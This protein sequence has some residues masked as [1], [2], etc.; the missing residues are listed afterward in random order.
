MKKSKRPTQENATTKPARRPPARKYAWWPWAVA[1][2]AL[3]L[4]FEAYTP[5]LNGAF[6][7][8]DRALAFD[9]PK[10]SA[11]DFAEWVRGVRPFLMT[12]YWLNY[13]SGGTDPYG[14]HATNV[15]LHFL[16]SA[17]I[18]L[19]AMRLV[20]MAG[21]AGRARTLCGVFAGGLFLL[22]PVQTESVA[23]VASRSEVLSVLLYFSAFALFLYRGSE[24]IGV[25]RALAIVAL[26]GAAVSTKEHTLTL[27]V[28]LVLADAWWGLGG[29]RRNGIVYGLMAV[30]AAGGAVLVWRV[31]AAANTAGFNVQGLTPA[32]Y[33]FTQCRVL[34][35]YV[36]LFF[37]P[38]GQNVDPDVAVSSG[39]L[40]H[41]AILGLAA[42]IA[43]VTVAWIY[44]KRFPLA[45]FGVLMFLLLLAPTSSIVPIRDVLAERR[46]YLPF[47]GLALVCVEVLRRLDFKPMLATSLA[48]LAISTVLTYQRSAVWESPQALWEDA[49]AKSPQ[50][51]RPR[52]QLAYAYYE[53]GQCPQAAE[54]Y[55]RA[56][57]LGAV[58]APLL[59]D[60][61]LALDCA[62]RGE[63]ALARLRTAAAMEPS[64]H[65]YAQIGMVYG[66]Q[67]KMALALEALQQAEQMDPRFEMTYVYRGNV[68]EVSGDRVAAARE[69]QRAVDINPS[70]QTARDALVR[71]SR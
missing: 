56:S 44:R 4:V 29:L 66:K 69:Y 48:A 7:L 19:V 70:N 42:W 50:K 22:H 6:V 47:L 13:E 39:I 27:P 17:V 67:R 8:D 21:V 15:F 61:A 63:E 12:S 26:F 60:W 20:A 51:L 3:F 58:D 40:D 16:G 10:V 46:L 36:R 25:L 43:V 64:A 34:W 33:F 37:L 28:L 18:A 59:V 38:Y 65:V 5:A 1:A 23:Y 53:L 32:T 49:A 71:V 2:G 62:G 68:Y 52:F 57:K 11:W 9:N 45:S 55:E 24:R 30:M 14:Y 54:N 35:M 41:G 31:L